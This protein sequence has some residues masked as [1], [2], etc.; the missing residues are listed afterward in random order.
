MWMRS[1]PCWPEANDK[2][3]PIVLAGTPDQSDMLRAATYHGGRKR[4]RAQGEER[5]LMQRCRVPI[6]HRWVATAVQEAGRHA[7]P[8][9]RL[10]DTLN[11][12]FSYS[13]LSKDITFAPLYP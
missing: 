6:V 1:E 11:R 3:V 4:W 12:F 2:D 7:I 5:A 9:M 13:S 8:H 10:A